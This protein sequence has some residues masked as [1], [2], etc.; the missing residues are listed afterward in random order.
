MGKNL[1]KHLKKAPENGLK[2]P[3]TGEKKP[4]LVYNGIDKQKNQNTKEE[5]TYYVQYT[6]NIIV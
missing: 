6:T 4:P 5:A 3:K 1:K 2:R